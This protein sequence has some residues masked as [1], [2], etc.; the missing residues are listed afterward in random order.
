MD[1]RC[2]VCQPR[3]GIVMCTALP[4]SDFKM[5]QLWKKK[6]NSGAGTAA[7]EFRCKITKNEKRRQDQRD[8]NC[9]S[10]HNVVITGDSL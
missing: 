8:L 10:G 6:R 5:S 2:A 7:A 9:I 3:C 1:L 4:G